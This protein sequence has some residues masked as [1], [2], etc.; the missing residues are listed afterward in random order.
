[1]TVVTL[2]HL[3]S[4][5]FTGAFQATMT[6]MTVLVILAFVAAGFHS[7]PMVGTTFLP[8]TSDCPPLL[9]APFSSS[10]IWVMYSY[11]GWNAAAYI[12]EEVTNPAKVL[13]RA[14]ILGTAFVT[15]LY[16]AVNAVFLYTTPLELLAKAGLD[17]AHDSGTQIFGDGGARITSSL[18]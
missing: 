2:F 7:A 13:P 16:V 3:R 11:S 8:K 9:A 5:R 14:L 17:V 15:F 12:V 18:I 10:L 1:V 4:L 6:G